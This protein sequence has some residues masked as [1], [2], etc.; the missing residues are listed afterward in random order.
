MATPTPRLTSTL[1]FGLLV[2]Y[3]AGYFGWSALARPG[4]E[5]QRLIGDWG[6]LPAFGLSAA[7]AFR[8]ALQPDAAR[9]WS[10]LGAGLMSWGLGYTVFLIYDQVLHTDAFPSL[11]DVGYLGAI[12]LF[13]AGLLQLRREKAGRLQ[14]L[15]LVID[16]LLVSAMLGD[17]I[18]VTSVRGLLDSY[19]GQ[20]LRRDVALAYPLGDLLLCAVTLNLA[21]R[22][23]SELAR[24]DTLLLAA[25]MLAFLATDLAYAYEQGSGTYQIGGLTDSGWAL[26][27]TFLGWAAYRHQ[28]GQGK[29]RRR[30]GEQV[31]G[32]Q[33]APLLP[34]YAVL[35]VFAAYVWR[36]L[37]EMITTDLGPL[38]P[39]QRTLMI[40]AVS[41]FMLRQVLALT[42]NQV[43]NLR[44]THRAEHD[45][46]TGARNRSDLDGL[47]QRLI[48]GSVSRNRLL[49]VLFIDLDRMKQ[50]NDTFGHPVG[51]LVLR[52]VARR[53]GGELRPADELAR[54][55]GDEFVV[56]MPDLES[57]SAAARMA[58]VLLDALARP[59]QIGP[60]TLSLTASIG[61]A[62]CPSDHGLAAG[63]L[64]YAD[65]AMYQ[66]K[67]A[68]KNTWR[69]YSPAL[70]RL[71][72]PQTQLEG[73]LRGALERGEF[74]LHFQPLR[75]LATHQTDSFEALLRWT[76]P[77]IGP[78]SPAEFI[79]VAE[80]REMMGGIGRWVLRR[81]LDAARRWQGELPGVGVAVNVSAT[82]FGAPDFVP[83]V[84]AALAEFGFEPSLLTLEITESA[85]LGNVAQ[86]RA[87]LTELRTLGVR[88]ALDDFG[89][90]YSSLGQLRALPVD[91][92]KIDR[93][94]VQEMQQ[95][96][97]AFVRAIV[98]LGHS[99]GLAVVAEGIESADV[100]EALRVL[101]CDVGQG[102]CFAR[103]MA[104][105]AAAAAVAAAAV[106][107]V[108][109][110]VS[111]AP[112]GLGETVTVQQDSG[113]A[114]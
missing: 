79:P 50:I 1:I 32:E 37:R 41:L 84:R 92:L 61:V 93:V 36:S 44:L 90:G 15:S 56:I 78:V 74:S 11:A 98:T 101:G 5:V 59:F 6:L 20:M 43:L 57:V 63:A 110:A 12:P 23:S 26:A 18:W 68:G 39:V 17:L 13:G 88:I 10:W 85:V 2:V 113:N 48:D 83:D 35:I 27:A 100:A 14:T 45:P 52:E 111:A 16:V 21:L 34:H 54:Y 109:V 19:P 94:F 3:T 46:L 82:S 58:Q 70:G 91:I 55:G 42:E 107:A 96:G 104:Y 86:A 108:A 65:T 53:L 33:W 106:A 69:F 28:G 76:S 60:E 114:P 89:T 102:Y 77:V 67:Q 112:S 49:A 71:H 64:A 75:V 47:L 9:I 105:E 24:R 8:A 30:R 81:A 51:D 4:A 99:L 72:A 38:D 62:L 40:V 66:A 87:T 22:R 29:A 25:G 73:L 103:P 80:A 7:L 97:A 31:R 95:Q